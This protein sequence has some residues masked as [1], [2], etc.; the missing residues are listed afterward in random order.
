MIGGVKQQY[1]SLTDGVKFA[2]HEPDEG[3]EVKKRSG[4]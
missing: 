3:E 1:V 2:A 4:S